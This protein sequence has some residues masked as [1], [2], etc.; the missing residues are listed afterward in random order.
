MS[1]NELSPA[2]EAAFRE[3]CRA[4]LDEHATG[5]GGER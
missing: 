4:F 1:E 3:R 5:V 2:E